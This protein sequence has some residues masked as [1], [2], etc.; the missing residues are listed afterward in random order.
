MPS[1]PLDP[2]GYFPGHGWRP[3][4]LKDPYQ[5]GWDVY[6]LQAKLNLAANA[7]LVADGIFGKLTSTAV[8]AFQTANGLVVDGIAGA[9]TQTTLGN[10]AAKK[11]KYPQRA[12]GQIQKE[13]SVLA[14]I[15]TAV[16][17]NGSQD[18]GPLQMNT[19]YHPDLGENFGVASALKVWEKHVED[20]HAKYL[21]W[22]VA[23]DRA[24]AAAQGAWNSP[25]Y[26]D[27]YAKGQAVPDS[28]IE[29]IEAVTVYV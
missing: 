15:Y 27:K 22:G 6:D 12:M 26:A 11:S 25:V 8:K 2:T 19:K 4:R 9:A 23:D 24:W 18:T 3:L 20:Y 13:S 10:A 29:Y 17:T 21:S 28:F 14:G 16:Y 7:G 5:R 1:F